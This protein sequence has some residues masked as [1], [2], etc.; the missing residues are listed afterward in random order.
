MPPTILAFVEQRNGALKKTAAEIL[1]AARRLADREA[2]GQVVAVLIGQGL[3]PLAGALG[4]LGADR[5]RLVEHADLANYSGDGYARVLAAEVAALKPAAVL[6]AAS[7]LG[8]DLAPRAAA[9]SGSGLAADCVELAWEGGALTAVRPVYAG[10]ARLKVRIE[11]RA[12]MASLRPN[13]F[14][15]PA[16]SHGR[17]AAVEMVAASADPLKDRVR[18]VIQAAAAKIDL[19]EADIIVTGGRGMKGPE[20]WGLIE[21]LAKVLGAA[22]GASRAVVDAG[23]RPHAEQVGQT[24]KTVCPS[25]YIACGVSGAIQHL[26]GMSSSKV[27]VAINKDPDAPIFKVAD[28]GIVGDVFEVLPRMTEELKKLRG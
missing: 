3:A 18:E 26:A 10:K 6:F 21:D 27:I 8:R 5:V 25:L 19:T 9:R 22:T 13:V 7:A 1:G 28:F 2:G 24:G 14:T 20:H 15:A 23:W 11:G 16:P 12:P 4:P 17:S